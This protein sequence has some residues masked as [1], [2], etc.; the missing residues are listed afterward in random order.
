MDARIGTC[1]IG[2][3]GTLIWSGAAVREKGGGRLNVGG[4]A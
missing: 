3:E 2:G 1:M 4:I